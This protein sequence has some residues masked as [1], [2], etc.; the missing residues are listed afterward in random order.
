MVEQDARTL[1][2]CTSVSHQNTAAVAQ[3]MA[4]VLDAEVHDPEQ[5]DPERVK[6]YDLVGFG[7]GIFASSHHPGLRR[8]AER[9]PEVD[10]VRAFVFSTSGI[11]RNQHRPWERSLEAL[12]RAKGF[13]V[14]GSFA[15]RG[16]DTWL[17][18]R[19]IGG[20]N[21]GHPDAADLERAREFARGLAAAG[22]TPPGPGQALA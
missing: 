11:G 8:F 3:A 17:P 12:L 19:L 21:K 4:E 10:G 16:W 5:I 22:A 20:L 15:C 18:L 14:V 2:V 13:D 1:I 6:D 9:L 7:S